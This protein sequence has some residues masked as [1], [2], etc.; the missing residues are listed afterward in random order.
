VV[1]AV[2]DKLPDIRV[3]A[4]SGAGL[5]E[6]DLGDW[7]SKRRIVLFAVPGAFTPTCHLN[8]LPGYIEHSESIRARGV[9]DIAVISVNDPY[10]MNEWAKST[11]ATGKIMFLAD[12]DAAFTKAIGM[13]MD[14]P[15]SGLGIRSKRYSMIV[16][17]GLVSRLNVEEM[18]KQT[19]IS[20]AANILSQLQVFA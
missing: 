17:D 13:E 9:D 14:F 11:R 18:P 20:G 7:M 8:H 19:E 15:T 16:E 12:F 1:I 2:G 10:V 6:L 3:K 4:A 5:L